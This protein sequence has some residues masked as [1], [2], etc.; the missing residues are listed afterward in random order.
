MSRE[1]LASQREEIKQLRAS[2]AAALKACDVA[3][4]GYHGSAV[5]ISTGEIRAALDPPNQTK[6]K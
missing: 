6:G 1:T 5:W 3:E 2:I 4:T